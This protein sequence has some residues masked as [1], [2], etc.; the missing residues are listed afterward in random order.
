MGSQRRSLADG[1]RASRRGDD[2]VGTPALG[3]IGGVQTALRPHGG[4]A[5]SP[6]GHSTESLMNALSNGQGHQRQG[7]SGSRHSQQ[8]PD[9]GHTTLSVVP[10]PGSRNR[11]KS[12][13]HTQR[14]SDR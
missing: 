13:R 8:E 9:N 2:H 11:K 10:Q 3:V 4:P 6:E 5:L 7:K 12:V 1:T 14:E